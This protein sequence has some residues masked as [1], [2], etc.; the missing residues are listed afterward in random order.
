M[1]FLITPTTSFD[2]LEGFI[3]LDQLPTDLLTADTDGRSKMQDG[4]VTFNELESVVRTFI[5]VG[6]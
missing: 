6:I 4:F 2:Q 5:L 1:G 3:A